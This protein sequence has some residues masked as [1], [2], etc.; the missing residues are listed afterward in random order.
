MCRLHFAMRLFLLCVP[1]LVL[2]ACTTREQLA[3]EQVEVDE[4]DSTAP[5]SSPPEEPMPSNLAT[6][7]PARI[8]VSDQG[9]FMVSVAPERG[10]I[11]VNQVHNWILH[12]ETSG[13]IPIDK[14]QIVVTGGMPEHGNRLPTIPRATQGQNHGDF[15]IQNFKFQTKGTWDVHF[16][17]TAGG[18]RDRVTVG[19]EL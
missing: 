7:N 15:L 9:Y 17:I 5:E 13:G 6:L 18:R 12:L 19:F 14:A 10:W 2:Q 8:Y 16:D 3:M 11:Q 4:T 1:F